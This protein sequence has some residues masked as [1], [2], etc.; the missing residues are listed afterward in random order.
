MNFGS[1]DGLPDKF[2]YSVTQDR[3]GF[4]WLGT[5]SGLYRYDGQKFQLFRSKADIPGREISNLL[6]NIY[7]DTGHDRLWLASLNTFQWFDLRTK[8]FAA[9]D[10]NDQSVRK[11]L[12]DGI[13]CFF[14]DS[15]GRMWIG[16]QKNYWCIFESQKGVTRIVHP[17]VKESEEITPFVI[18]IMETTDG[19]M[20]SLTSEGLYEF[21]S[22]ANQVIRRIPSNKGM[23]S[24]TTFSGGIYDRVNNCLWLAANSSG[25]CRYQLANDTYSCTRIRDSIGNPAKLV[26]LRVT[27]LARRS[28]TQLW[29]GTWKLGIFDIEKK[30]YTFVEDNGLRDFGFR[31]F[32]ISRLFTDNEDNLWV[33]S[34]SGFSM[35]PWQNKQ[36]SYIPLRDPGTDLLIEPYGSAK[37]PGTNDILVAGSFRSGIGWIQNSSGKLIIIPH[38]RPDGQGMACI[39][40]AAN[41]EIYCGDK[42]G[43]Y[44]IQTNPAR[45]ALLEFTEENGNPIGSVTGI[46]SDPSGQLYLSSDNNGFYHVDV[47]NHFVKHYHIGDVEQ[48][49][50]PDDLA[51]ILIPSYADKS[52][53]IWLTGSSGVYSFN[54]DDKRFKRQAAF[55]ALNTGASISKPVGITEDS[56]GHIWITSRGTGLFELIPGRD[57]NP[58]SLMN[59]SA[60]NA[61]LPSDYCI[62]LFRDGKNY[63]WIATLNGLV[64]FDP[65]TRKAITILKQQ[66][67]FQNDNFDVTM[68]GISQNEIVVNFYGGLNVLNV[69]DYNSNRFVP[70]PVLSSLQVQDQES[71]LSQISPET[72]FELRYNQNYLKFEF[73]SPGYNNGNQNRFAYKLE[74]ADPGWIFSGNRNLVSYSGLPPGEYR[75]YLKAANNDGLWSE[76]VL[77]TTILILAP[78]WQRGWFYS[79]CIAFA[80]VLF[81]GWNRYHVRRVRREEQLKSDF[82]QQMAEIEMKALRA[83]MN[84]HFIFNSLNSINN[85]ILKNNSELA[86]QYL[87]KFSRFVR[88]VLD[89]SNEALGSLTD[90]VEL[91]KLYI[92]I[93]RMRFEDKFEY[94]IRI[95]EQ[96]SPEKIEIP[97]MLLQPYVENAIWHGLVHKSGKGKL[98]I[99]FERRGD[100]SLSV[101][102]EDDGVGREKA[103]ELK[104]RQIFRKKSYGMKISSDRINILNRFQ[105]I[106]AS[107][108]IEDLRDMQGFPSGTRVILELPI[109]ENGSGRNI[110]NT[111][112]EDLNRFLND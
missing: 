34:F 71:D 84:P 24:T 7:H 100:N 67:G 6:L 103:A 2:I 19:R 80:L 90:E 37:V 98:S 23:D 12:K 72:P 99:Q 10:Y 81:F 52:G 61:D 38:P 85:Y 21:E 102:I 1:A 76:P 65:E 77:Q 63:L 42:Y 32:N 96:L 3:Q 69:A 60:A 92:E 79:I 105:G 48:E 88:K 50:G 9:P 47:R 95:G 53:K 31:T 49:N 41:G 104:S 43:L 109:S 33:A 22:N 14:R 87:V 5:S 4:I 51:D 110:K 25:I 8:T 82:R 106:P 36:V 93:E 73:M 107:F 16:T 58:D 97:S 75:F 94:E 17:A 11:L 83:Q 101:V 29:L 68:N 112:D 46:L 39:H 55:P 108:K 56:R 64:K 44:T 18:Q 35:Q 74:G 66:H 70:N 59:F 28:A 20:W 30:T 111:G 27:S 40:A 54:P 26:S 45:L 78:F 62:H 89:H 15:K 57:D 86:S 13:S 91:L